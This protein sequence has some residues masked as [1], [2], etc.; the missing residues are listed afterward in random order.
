MSGRRALTR[1]LT[2]ALIRALRYQIARGLSVLLV[3]TLLRVRVEGRIHLPPVPY[4]LCFSH[5]S[6]ADPFVLMAVLPARPQVSFFGPQ[7]EDMSRGRRN[8]LMRWAGNAVPYRPDKNDLR[9]VS[10]RVQAIFDAGGILAIAGEGRIH[11]HE[12]EVLPLNEGAAFFALR[13][14]V[15]IVPVAVN[16]MTW[17][18]VGSRVRIRVGEPIAVEGRPTSEAVAALTATTW[19]ALRRLALDFPSR[20]RPGRIGRW[21]TELFNDW[22]EGARPD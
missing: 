18:T 11:A 2:R 21:L 8:R 16:G 3:R 4:L 17:F 15:P 12:D 19:A 20:A 7:Q 1:A 9:D 22:P 10:R 13:A 14:G 5:E 6:W